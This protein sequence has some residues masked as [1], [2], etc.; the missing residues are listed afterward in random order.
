MN[1][2]DLV[3]T[4]FLTLALLTA[5]TV[6]ASAQSEGY[7]GFQG[8]VV[9]ANMGGDMDAMGRQLADELEAEL[10]GTWTS[11]KKSRTGFTGGLTYTRMF[12]PTTGLQV[13]AMY[14]SR[15][16]KF[17][18]ATSGGVLDTELKFNYLEIPILLRF[19]PS[20]E[21]KTQALLMVGPVIGFEMGS[22]IKISGGGLSAEEDLDGVK[23]VTFGLAAAAGL[24]IALNEKN[25]LQ[26]QARYQFGL[27]NAID[28]PEYSSS[29]SDLMFMAGMEF[30]LGQ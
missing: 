3:R 24:R 21:A 23:S 19:A 1:G 27:S 16:V 18:L 20:P 26:L 2:K 17:D 8:G 4:V 13:E 5:W 14:A 30:K 9:L 29:A 6:A 25:A 11:S 22:K 15:G 12:K 28:D 7:F 10:G